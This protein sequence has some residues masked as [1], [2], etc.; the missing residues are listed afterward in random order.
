MISCFSSAR[1][2]EQVFSLTAK[3]IP[4]VCPGY[5]KEA[6]LSIL[7][8]RLVKFENNP[9]TTA[10]ETYGYHKENGTSLHSFNTSTLLRS[11]ASSPNA[12]HPLNIPNTHKDACSAGKHIIQ[13]NQ[14][15]K[16]L[17]RGLLLVLETTKF[18]VQVQA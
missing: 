5:C 2:Q 15:E 12:F 10:M 1:C 11:C 3:D 4:S 6:M 16:K 18:T 7:P 14:P 8:F 17:C 9:I 13:V